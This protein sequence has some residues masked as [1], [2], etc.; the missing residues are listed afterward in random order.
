MMLDSIPVVTRVFGEAHEL[1]LRIRGIYGQT[2]Y[3]D[4]GATLDNLREAVNFNEETVRTARRVLGGTHPFVVEIEQ[5]LR[6]SREALS[7]CET[8]PR[9]E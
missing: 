8:S 4:T 5:A 1:T 3:M 9:D 2:L 7:T 6:C